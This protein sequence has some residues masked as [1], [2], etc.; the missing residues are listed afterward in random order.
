MTKT[1]R[2]RSEALMR[3]RIVAALLFLLALVTAGCGGGGG[4]GGE[5]GG[6]TSIPSVII[7]GTLF[8]TTANAVIVGYTV[9]F[10]STGPSG[11][12]NTQGA[13]SFSVPKTD[14]TGSDVLYILD[15]SGTPISTQTVN[16][17]TDAGA[18]GTISVGPPGVPPI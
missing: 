4:G 6:S 5:G 11:V 3:R 9:R 16:L 7:H 8:S 15:G 17:N 10:G 13:F 14:I 2:E 12:T 18:V 1:S